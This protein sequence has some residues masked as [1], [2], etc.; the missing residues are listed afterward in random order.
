MRYL[1][2]GVLLA[3]PCLFLFTGSPANGLTP[4]TDAYARSLTGAQIP[5]C[6]EYIEETTCDTDVCK[7]GCKRTEACPGSHT[8]VAPAGGAPGPFL[9]YE[10]LILVTLD[11]CFTT[12]GKDCVGPTLIQNNSPSCDPE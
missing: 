2:L 8:Y 11:E 10:E 1:S 5:D 12:C 7:N 6:S 9:L 3:L 4:V